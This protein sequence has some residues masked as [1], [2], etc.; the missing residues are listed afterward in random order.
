M[1]P[2]PTPSFAPIASYVL[3]GEGG[4]QRPDLEA[5]EQHMDAGDVVW[6]HLDRG[7][8]GT[9]EWLRERSG[10]DAVTCDALLYPDTRPRAR[11]YGRGIM[12]ILRVPNR[13][14]GDSQED[15]VALRLWVEARRMISVRLRRVDT[16]AS[17]GRQLDRGQGPAD[18][19]ALLSELVHGIL[20][21]LEPVLDDLEE[22]VDRAEEA[23]QQRGAARPDDSLA[24]LR[25]ELAIYYR[26]LKPQQSALVHLGSID[27]LDWFEPPAVAQL[28]EASERTARMTEDLETLRERAELV[29]EEWQIR[30]SD[31]LNRRMYVSA[32]A[33]ALFLPLTFVTGMLGINVG[34]IPLADDTRGFMLVCGVVLLLGA[35]EVCVL[36][37]RRWL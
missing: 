10:L 30:V 12:L 24:R 37:R 32:I 4:A 25:R 15:M 31:Q 9:E 17:V 34:G 20:D 33:A 16:A 11:V 13:N 14:E 29:Y 19:R 27:Y 26:H 2:D 35:L 21:R 7:V 23:L 6:A 28:H 5:F 1:A 18:T 3:D 8:E 22:R 36:W